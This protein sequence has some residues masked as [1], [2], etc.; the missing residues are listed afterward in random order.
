MGT[1]AYGGKGPGKGKGRGEGRLGQGG[2]GRSNGG[3]KPMGTTAYGGKGSKGRAA[4]GHRPVGAASCRR[5][6]HTMASCHPPPPRC[7]NPPPAFP[8]S[9]GHQVCHAVP[10]R[11]NAS[12]LDCLP[13]A[14]PIGLSPLL[15][16]TLRGPERVWAG[17]GGLGVLERRWPWLET[18]WGGLWG[19]LCRCAPHPR[20]ARAT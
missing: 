8:H 1:V 12:V 4:N 13:L 5:D 2:R 19:I 7:R 10:R 17:E 18:D 3:E 11:H 20:N 15:I 6:Q 16:L 9:T 14:A